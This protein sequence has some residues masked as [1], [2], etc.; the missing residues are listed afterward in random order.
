[1][2]DGIM[3]CLQIALAFSG[4][5]ITALPYGAYAATT[6]IVQAGQA[7]SETEISVKRG[8]HVTFRNQDDVNHNIMVQSGDDDD[9]ARDMGVQPPGGDVDV[10]FDASGKFKVRCHIHP[11]MKLNVDVQ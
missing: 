6:A 3:R 8:D 2:K 9:N 7:F 5:A 11:S 4:L 1:M 10:L